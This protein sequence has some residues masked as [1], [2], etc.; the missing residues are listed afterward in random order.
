M[1]IAVVSLWVSVSIAG[2]QTVTV[3]FDEAMTVRSVDR[4][5]P[6]QHTLYIVAE[7]FDAHLAAMEYK[8]DYPP[9]MKWIGDV[10]LP[11]LKIGKTTEGIAQAWPTPIDA[12]SPV[13]VA[14]VLVSWEP[15]DDSTCELAVVPHP[16]SGFVRAVAAQDHSI[17]EAQGQTSLIG[18]DDGPTSPRKF[19][20]LFGANPNP[21]KPV[22]QITYW[23]PQGEHVRLGVYDVT[24][25]LIATLV[26]DARDRGEY[27]VQWR[28]RDLPSGVY[29]CRL[30]VGDYTESKKMMLL[31]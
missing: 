8:I 30:E 23:V 20:V 15:T 18:A 9:G 4:L 14:K 17:V 22:T 11:P 16:G 12:H 24:G 31:K 6:G 3:Y 25:R 7:G 19:P 29:F 5:S 27:T 1:C 13:V 28:A 10:D 26:D 21:F 2:T